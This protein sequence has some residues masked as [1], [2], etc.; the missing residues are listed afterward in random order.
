MNTECTP[1]QMEFQG[2]GRRKVEAAFDGGHLSSDGGALL[3]RELDLRYT[4]I[5]RLAECFTDSPGRTLC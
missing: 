5:E 1:N 4:I 3:L 2:I